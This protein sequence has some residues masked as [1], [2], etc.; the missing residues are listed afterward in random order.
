M[1][2]RAVLL[3]SVT[4]LVLRDSTGF[5]RAQ[6]SEKH[7]NSEPPASI[8]QQL[9]ALRE[10]QDRLF[11]ELEQIRALL[12]EKSDKITVAPAPPPP[13]KLI[14]LNLKGEPFRGEASARVA[15]VEYSDFACPFCAEYVRDTFPNIEKNYLKPGKVKYFFRDLPAPEHTNALAAACAARCAGEQGKFWEMHDL[16][17]AAQSAFSPKDLTSYAQ[18]LG[19]DTTQFNQCLASGKYEQVIRRV[20]ASAERLGLYGTPVFLIG[21]IGDDGNIFRATKVLVGGS[22]SQ[23][24]TSALD[25]VLDGLTK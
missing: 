19:L 25:E 8:Q 1:N 13:S 17:F 2:A 5:L 23:A 21:T 11:K 16:L 18:G 24:L 20:V 7:A 15:I 9:D 10:G 14:T 3:L 22:D 6:G 4:A 12:Q